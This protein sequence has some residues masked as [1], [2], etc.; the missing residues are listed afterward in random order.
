MLVLGRSVDEVIV[1]V[2]PPSNSK[3]TVQVVVTEI[4]RDSVRLGLN[5]PKDTAM[6]RKEI[7]QKIEEKQRTSHG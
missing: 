1:I 4:R 6:H 5:A 3:T 2:V 7:W